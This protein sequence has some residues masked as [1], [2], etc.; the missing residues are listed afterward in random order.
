MQ[1]NK[2]QILSTKLVG[3]TLIS[4]AAM[5]DI[6]I[7]EVSFIETE[8]IITP[9]LQKRII[10]LSQQNVTVVFTSVNAVNAVNRLL[11]TKTFWKIFCIDHKTKKLVENIF[12]DEKIIGTAD[13]AEQ[14]A[15][16]IIKNPCLQKVVFFCGD[17][18]RDELPGK[19][20]MNGIE[21]EELVVYKTIEKAHIISKVYDGILFFSPSAVKSFFSVNT[22]TDPTQIFAIGATTAEEAKLFTHSPI[23]I[24]EFPGKENLVYQVIKHF[25]TIKTF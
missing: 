5:Y 25:S 3:E 10:E 7:D 1:K 23:I 24:A 9:T 4:I 12:G 20:K 22:I 21:L 19:L 17:H 13:N 16:K 6:L 2:I 14:L 8:E 11:P 18:R 15:E